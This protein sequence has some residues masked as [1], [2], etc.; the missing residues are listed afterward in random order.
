MARFHGEVGFGKSVKDSP[1]VWED[2]IIER[3]YQ[4]D[5]IRNVRQL[6]SADGVN[7][8]ITVANSISI[9]ADQYAVENFLDI[10]YV[11]WM[12]EE[13]IV[14]NVEVRL[15]RLILSLGGVFHGPTA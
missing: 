4:G 5:V 15:P 7:D 14:P 12:G 9:V 10:K 6:E 11:R 3:P 13:W 1:G 2:E 8:N